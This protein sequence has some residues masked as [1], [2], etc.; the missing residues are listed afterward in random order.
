MT[1]GKQNLEAVRERVEAQRNRYGA[2][3]NQILKDR[4]WLL[5]EID[6]LRAEHHCPT[7]VCPDIEA[8]QTKTR[9]RGL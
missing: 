1:Y 9:R 4:A 6:R 3:W 2:R 5:S 8:T 7:C